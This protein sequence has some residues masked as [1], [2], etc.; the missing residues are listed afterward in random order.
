MLYLSPLTLRRACSASLVVGHMAGTGCPLSCY[1]WR[2][3]P[4]SSSSTVYRCSDFHPLFARSERDS[5]A[6]ATGLRLSALM[7]FYI[8]PLKEIF[9]P[10]HHK[11][12]SFP[13]SIYPLYHPLSTVGPTHHF[14]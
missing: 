4:L 6:S 1:V 9:Y 8:H 11:I 7:H 5:E 14:I 12:Y 13:V 2:T 3:K 10:S